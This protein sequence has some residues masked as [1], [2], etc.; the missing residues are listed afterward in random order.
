MSYNYNTVIVSWS[1]SNKNDINIE[2]NMLSSLKPSPLCDS[3]LS[4]TVTPCFVAC[5]SWWPQLWWQYLVFFLVPA[6]MLLLSY[7]NL[8]SVCAAVGQ[9]Y[10]SHPNLHHQHCHPEQWQ[11]Q[12]WCCPTGMARH[13]Y[14]LSKFGTSACLGCNVQCWHHR[15]LEDDV[16]GGGGCGWVKLALMQLTM[17]ARLFSIF[18][19]WTKKTNWMGD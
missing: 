13:C 3:P 2:S 19:L 11:C 18:R 5:Q 6:T 14:H 8:P 15:T 7:V 12:Q 4:T 17:T 16:S 9:D 1:Y 10:S